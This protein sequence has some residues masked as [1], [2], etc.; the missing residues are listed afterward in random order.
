MSGP[1]NGVR[2]LDLT[3][4][5][6]GP[7]AS[8]ILGDMGADVIKVEHPEG[9]SIRDI[10]PARNQGMG[11]MFL[12]TNRGKR[13]IVLNLKSPAGCAAFK[14]LAAVSDVFVCN[15]RPKAM[16]R[17]GLSYA[18]LADVNPEIIYVNIVGYGSD[19]PTPTSPPTM[20]S[21]RPRPA[22]RRCGPHTRPP[23]MRPSPS[24]IASL[25][26]LQPTRRWERFIIA[27]KAARASML[28]YLCSNPLPR[29][30]WPT[31]WRA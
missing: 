11:A 3:T 6:S 26:S 14:R 28:K 7:V 24:R 15:A 30:C 18:D 5:L 4:A 23:A 12:H 27:R 8:Q 20:I 1:L 29:W 31:I 13:S 16:R 22:L 2:V 19:G 17:L 10:G 9:D 25:E 21:F